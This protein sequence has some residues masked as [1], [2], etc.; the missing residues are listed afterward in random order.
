[1]AVDEHD[2]SVDGHPEEGLDAAP[3]ESGRELRKAK[4]RTPY[5]RAELGFRNYWYPAAASREITD[6]PTAVKILGDAIMLT[7]RDGKVYAIADSCPHRGTQLSLGKCMVPGTPTISCPYH[8]WTF[9][10]RDGAC[11]AVLCEG[12]E[13]KIVGRAKVRTYP[14]EDRKGIIWI[15]MG[16]GKPAPLEEDVP[17]LLLREDTVVRTRHRV[18]YGNWRF[19]AENLGGGHA[20]VLHR[21]ALGVYFKA[22][23]A[24]PKDVRGVTGSDP[25]GDRWVYQEVN[26]GVVFEGD[27]PGVGKWPPPPGRLRKAL[28]KKWAATAQSPMFGVNHYGSALR[29]PGIARSLH[30]PF[31]GCMYYEW[32]VAVDE[33]HY[34]YF[35]VSCGWPKT[36][37]ERAKWELK[38]RL[39]G[40]PFMVK[41]FNDMDIGMVKQTTD[42]VKRRNGSI[43]YLS[44]L[45]KQDSF[46]IEWRRMV[47][48]W[49]R[50]E[51]DEWLKKNGKAPEAAESMPDAN[52]G[53]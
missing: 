8:G 26:G 36:P 20:Q 23:P 21:E 48:A 1:M 25:D 37:A 12:P 47:N 3:P 27:Y 18:L 7:R 46:H 38:Y 51:G 17:A 35:Q 41:R 49:A 34:T 44:K 33:D 53:E 16:R 11:V 43:M 24:Y 50:G 15:W 31:E 22:I 52:T 40:K 29:L 14:I 28:T 13:S 42:W 45:T 4:G 5:E 10:V 6:K 9:D 39:Y 19:H 32:W 2:G 30:Y